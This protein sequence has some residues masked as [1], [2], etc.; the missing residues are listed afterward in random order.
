[1]STNGLP[2]LYAHHTCSAPGHCGRWTERSG[3][4]TAVKKLLFLAVTAVVFGLATLPASAQYNPMFITVSPTA[5]ESC[6]TDTGTITVNA[7]YFEPGS[8]VTV[9]LQSDPVVLGTV[10]ASG[11]GTINAT[12]NLPVG[13]TAGAH[14]VIASGPRLDTGVVDSVSAA[15]TVTIPSACISPSTLT[16]TTQSGG[17]SLPVTGSDNGVFV[18]VG[19]GLLVAGGLL[20]MASR[21]R[22]AR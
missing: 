21:K 10:A 15:I 9:T 4:G 5:V 20:V 14:T 1:V 18:A 19:A 2:I 13:V 22:N 11:T 3:K 7:G 12:F 8:T 16:P 6:G 17:G